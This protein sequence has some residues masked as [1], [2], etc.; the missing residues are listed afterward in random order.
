MINTKKELVLWIILAI[1][2]AYLFAFM[3]GSNAK[4]GRTNP[5]RGEEEDLCV[6][7]M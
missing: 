7:V 1:S 3:S 5:E 4:A 6:R 2:G